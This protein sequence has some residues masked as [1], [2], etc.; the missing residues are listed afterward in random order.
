VPATVA[1]SSPS[2][3]R[4]IVPVRALPEALRREL[5][6]LTLSGSVY[7]ES[8]AQRLLIVNGQV[9][10]EGQTLAAGLTLEQIRP[11][12]AVFRYKDHRFEL[13]F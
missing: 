12:G 1:P 10:H 13:T 7:S 2:A 11:K 4:R 6:A 8:P 3:E 5:P 9:V